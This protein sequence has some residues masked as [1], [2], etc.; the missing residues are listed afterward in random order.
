MI[1]LADL[2]MS[3]EDGT[4]L[5]RQPGGI[6]LA[7]VATVLIVHKLPRHARAEV[8]DETLDSAL[9]CWEFGLTRL[10]AGCWLLGFSFITCR[11]PWRR[12]WRRAVSVIRIDKCAEGSKRSYHNR[13]ESCGLSACILPKVPGRVTMASI[14]S[15]CRCA[16]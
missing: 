5:A 2:G 9:G 11:L 16:Y 3:S 15:H 12:S 8:M 10:A 1:R 13:A 4:L 7:Q 14:L 6:P